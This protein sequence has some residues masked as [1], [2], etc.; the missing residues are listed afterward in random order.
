MCTTTKANFGAPLHFDAQSCP[1]LSKLLLQQIFELVKNRTGYF[2]RGLGGLHKIQ[3]FC[4][5][6]L[7]RRYCLVCLCWC[8]YY[9]YRLHTCSFIDHGKEKDAIPADDPRPPRVSIAAR[10]AAS[11][12]TTLVAT[13]NHGKST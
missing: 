5:P 6:T 1:F 11:E 12:C 10:V 13:D 2:C 3:F 7:A 9:H 4:F 8:V